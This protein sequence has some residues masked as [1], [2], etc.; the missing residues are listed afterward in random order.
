MENISNSIKTS[1]ADFLVALFDGLNKNEIT[2]CVLRNFDTLPY[3]L[4]GSDID[5]FVSKE[6]FEKFHEILIQIATKFEGKIISKLTTPSV[7]DVA[8]CGFYNNEWWGIRFDTFTYIGTNECAIVSNKYI[9][10]RIEFHNKIKVVNR[11]DALIIGF[12]KEIIG[13][14][15]YSHRY[16]KGALKAYNAEQENYTRAFRETLPKVLV[17]DCLIP[18]L[19]DESVFSKHI[20]H[21][22]YK[23][24]RKKAFI[25]NPK[26]HIVN[27]IGSFGYKLKRL[28]KTPGFSV[29][30][31]GTDGSGKTT[32]IN[33]LIPLLEK[34]LHN[35]IV[36]SHMRPNTI[37]NI[38]QLFGKP[39]VDGLNENPH[40]GSASGFLGSFLRL[41][42][43]TFDYI[44]GYW[45][46][47]NITLA[48][49][50]TIW[51]FDRYYY[52]YLIDQK[53]A[54]INLPKWLINF[55][56]VFIPA[57]D[58]II[59][60]GAEPNLIYARKPELPLN[61][62]KKQINKL[63]TFSKTKE[64]AVWVDTGENSLETTI[65]LTML[66]IINKMS[67]RYQ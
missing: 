58:L 41:L 17:T 47:V 1:E 57:P 12:V 27:T 65:N 38:A 25:N 34:P 28:I 37:P 39:K 48:K 61:E 51:F 2:Y 50:T 20:C 52:D 21:K 7:K 13:A 64:N 5:V 26:K 24:Y 54:R 46:K 45:T 31:M 3:H 14:K 60:L 30:I 18:L 15:K 33:E 63:K 22:L 10:D 23:G 32:V 16:S 49:K 59:C 66:H 44:F 36:C 67:N 55:I 42:Y 40:Q 9:I 35:K 29:A 43:Y 62:I 8:I 56:E 53:R 4:N 11:N 19:K 6:D